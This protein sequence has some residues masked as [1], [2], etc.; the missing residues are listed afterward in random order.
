MMLNRSELHD[1]LQHLNKVTK[2]Q[3]KCPEI[4]E[5]LGVKLDD[6]IFRAM[7]IPNPENQMKILLLDS[8]EDFT[9]NFKDEEFYQ[10]PDHLK[11]EPVNIIYCKTDQKDILSKGLD[12]RLKF[13]LIA[14]ENVSDRD[15]YPL[16]LVKIRSE[17]KSMETVSTS[18]SSKN[19]SVNLWPTDCYSE[20]SWEELADQDI[21]VMEHILNS[22]QKKNELP[23]IASE[24]T[25][26]SSS[27]NP[28]INPEML[29]AI[30][31]ET[32]REY[33]ISREKMTA[34]EREM[35]D[36]E[37]QSFDDPLKAVLGYHPNDERKFC[38]YYDPT[39]GGCFKGGLC[40]LH[41]LPD[42]KDGATRDQEVCHLP[43]EP[44]LLPEDSI[45]SVRISIVE[46]PDVFYAQIQGQ[47]EFT[48]KQLMDHLN[49]PNELKVMQPFAIDP[50]FGE[51]VFAPYLDGKFYRAR[52]LHKI[53]QT[54]KVSY[55]FVTFLGCVLQ[56]G[57][58][59]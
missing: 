17:T 7:R 4:G 57:M 25:V 16:H 11:T 21:D 58:V 10:L 33:A 13:Q 24:I 29:K 2:K 31:M 32:K 45:V 50:S 47:S 1:L 38:R 5:I 49:L 54:C 43:L 12:V 28:F 34:E 23:K 51:I 22:Q 26:K 56:R 18:S 30:E 39:T 55:S 37:P 19:G 44:I 48:L 40:T 6:Q 9:C 15:L 14:V 27:T 52:F 41:H 36:E 3:K 35:F 20:G 46:S 53:D 8:A 42:L 59:S